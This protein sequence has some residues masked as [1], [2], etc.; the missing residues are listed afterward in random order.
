MAQAE[1]LEYTAATAH[2]FERAT[3]LATMSGALA[4]APQALDAWATYNFEVEDLHTYVADNDDAA[5]HCL[6]RV[7]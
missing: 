5:Q 7:A 1:R 4:I 6:E 3:G 2:M